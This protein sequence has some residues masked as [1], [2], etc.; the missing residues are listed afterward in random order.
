MLIL[1]LAE[2]NISS[3]HSVET[4]I[5]SINDE[6]YRRV[7][8]PFEACIGKHLRHITD[9]YQMM[10]E[11]LDQDSV[12]LVQVDYDGRLRDQVEEAERGVMIL[13]LRQICNRLH[14]L[15]GETAED[16]PLLVTLTV[17][18]DREAPKVASSLGRELVFLQGHNAHHCAIISAILSLQGIGVEQDFGV[19]PSTLRYEYQQQAPRA[20]QVR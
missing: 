2:A 4:T 20:K 8:S 19:A 15:A 1:E 13:R 16:Q 3:L 11:A 5:L 10:F 7:V 9:H 18:K 14:K 6:Q 17:D 12:G